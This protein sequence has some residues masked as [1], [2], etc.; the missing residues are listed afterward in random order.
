MAE[1]V[2][3]LYSLERYTILKGRGFEP[4][5]MRSFSWA[6]RSKRLNELTRV[7]TAHARGQERACAVVGNVYCACAQTSIFGIEREFDFLGGQVRMRTCVRIR[8]SRTSKNKYIQS[9]FVGLLIPGCKGCMP[10]PPTG[11]CFRGKTQI[12]RGTPKKMKVDS[13]V[14]VI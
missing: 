10:N 8:M 9:V 11:V 13:S 12:R 2:S 14:V 7:R 5:R 1:L 3:A 6:S 4:P